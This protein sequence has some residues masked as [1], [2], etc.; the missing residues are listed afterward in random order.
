MEK[1]AGRG[2]GLAAAPPGPQPLSLTTCRTRAHRLQAV[3][4]RAFGDDPTPC[5]NKALS[6]VSVLVIISAV[7]V[8]ALETVPDIWDSLGDG[9]IDVFVAVE[10]AYFAA[11]AVDYSAR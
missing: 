11:A 8:T 3:T 10:L 5:A 4:W 9:A 1:R 2:V 6:T 7:M